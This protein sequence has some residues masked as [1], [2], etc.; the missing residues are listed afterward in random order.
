MLPRLRKLRIDRLVRTFAGGHKTTQTM[1]RALRSLFSV[2]PNLEEAALSHGRM[3]LSGAER[4][5]GKAE[6]P[7]PE[8]DGALEFLP[9][10]CLRRASTCL[11]T[12]RH[13]RP[14][15]WRL[16]GPRLHCILSSLSSL[17][18]RHAWPP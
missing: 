15:C 16:H 18:A 5:A 9:A 7:L 2:A 14:A 11:R 6:E 4:K 1:G 8:C 12:A 13:G 3:Y 10:S 17:E